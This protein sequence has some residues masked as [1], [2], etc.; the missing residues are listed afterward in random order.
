M[1][2]FY[3]TLIIILGGLAAL[4]IW[5]PRFRTHWRGTRF[6]F[7]P[8]SCAGLAFLLFAFGAA[9]LVSDSIRER[10]GGWIVAAVATAWCV[11][12][13]GYFI[14]RRAHY[15]TVVR[16]SLAPPEEHSNAEPPIEKK[17]PTFFMR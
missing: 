2:Y 12:A 15:E 7:G 10:Y 4:C 8:V 17:D 6:P 14:D 5:F 16:P 1:R 9:F 3:S 11:G 13:V